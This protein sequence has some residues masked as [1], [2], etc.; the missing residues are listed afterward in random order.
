[1]STLL[2]TTQRHNPEDRDMKP[3]RHETSNL[4]NVV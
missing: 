3:H 2:K 1:V 4:A